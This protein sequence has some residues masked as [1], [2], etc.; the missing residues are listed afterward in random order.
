MGSIHAILSL[1]LCEWI[2]IE[3]SGSEIPG[4][5]AVP[6]STLP[7]RLRGLATGSLL[8]F[9]EIQVFN[10]QVALLKSVL[11]TWDSERTRSCQR[12]RESPLCGRWVTHLQA[13]RAIDVGQRQGPMAGTNSKTFEQAGSH[14]SD[15]WV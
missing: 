13:A 15:L 11:S 8:L 14:V 3:E 6:H 1:S 12:G 5:W 9:L 7:D 2:A 4:V 10:E